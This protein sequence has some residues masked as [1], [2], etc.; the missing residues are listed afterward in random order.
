[1]PPRALTLAELRVVWAPRL[2]L[3]FAGAALLAIQFLLPGNP[4]SRF[5]SGA[6]G[7]RGVVVA[8]IQADALAA[9]VSSVT[10]AGH[11]TKGLCYEDPVLDACRVWRDKLLRTRRVDL[12]LVGNELHQQFP[13]KGYGGIETSVENIASALHRMGIPFW[14][15]TPGRSARPEYPFD[16]LETQLASNGR[17]G[18]ANVFV[19]EAMELMRN[20]KDLTGAAL[21]IVDR[22]HGALKSAPDGPG[23]AAARPLVIWGQSDWSQSFAELSAVTITSHHDGGGPV[24]HLSGGRWDRHIKHVGHRFLSHDQ[25]NQWVLPD[26]ER[27]LK[28][29]R[30]I[31]HGL[32]PEDY[33]T[34]EDGGYFLW[35]AGL[36]WGWEEKGLHIFTALARMR[37]ELQFVAYGVAYRRPDLEER[38]RILS[39]ELPN[40]DFR[41]QLKRGDTHRRVFCEATAF[42]MPTQ[43]SIGESFGMTVIESLSKGVPVIASTAGAVPEILD[44]EGRHGYSNQ[45][46]AC[47][48]LYEYEAALNKCVIV[49]GEGEGGPPPRAPLL[50]P[51]TASP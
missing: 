48:E 19:E 13:L 35:V 5:V 2:L 10:A 9:G 8:P 32:P 43:P 37:P 28:R 38:L 26:D 27:N 7:S 41:G 25:R 21:P 3:V 46:A 14:V 30:V 49:G 39:Y 51:P 23:G 47:N 16:V 34:C 29:T 15:V 50:L 1:M 24:G 40:F 20:R 36:D 11:A 22:W 42:F 4:L 33:M 45:G 44:V 12:V 17:H 18:H 6:G 31:P